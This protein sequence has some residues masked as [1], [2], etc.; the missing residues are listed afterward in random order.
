MGTIKPGLYC[1]S[2]YLRPPPPLYEDRPT[3]II[4]FIGHLRIKKKSTTD[5]F[6]LVISVMIMINI[7]LCNLQGMIWLRR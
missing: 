3:K 1:E 2:I 7:S 4:L 5:K 6:F